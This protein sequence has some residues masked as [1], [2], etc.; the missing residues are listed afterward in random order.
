MGDGDDVQLVGRCLA[1]DTE[2]FRPLVERYEHVVF[3]LGLR[4][5]GDREEARDVAQAA[6]IKVYEN[7]GRYDARFRF[8]SWLYRIA[9]NECLN[10]RN[11]RR[12]HV[13]LDPN[14]PAPDRPDE[15][16]RQAEVVEQVRG[17][18]MSL[19]RDYRDVVVLRHFAEL[20][21]AEM[22]AVLQV[23]EKTVKSRLHTARQRLGERL[24]S[25]RPAR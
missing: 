17:A 18:V 12:Q 2:A 4:L 19:S 1:G 22:S 16:V 20:S 8:Y 10:V 11:R 14:L 6:F 3:N 23:P 24:L 9:L 15:G 13:P 5:L 21:Y 25:W 7:L